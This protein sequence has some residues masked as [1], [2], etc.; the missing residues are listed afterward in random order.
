MHFDDYKKYF[1]QLDLRFLHNK[2]V[3]FMLFLFVYFPLFSRNILEKNLYPSGPSKFRKNQITKSFR[4]PVED[5]ENDEESLV[6]VV[7]MASYLKVLSGLIR[8]GIIN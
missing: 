6:S 7:S 8:S 3:M 4:M 1:P 2:N 5:F